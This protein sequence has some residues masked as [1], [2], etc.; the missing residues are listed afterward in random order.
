MAGCAEARR[1]RGSA[2]G[3]ALWAL[4]QGRSVAPFSPVCSG[5]APPQFGLAP[6]RPH[7]APCTPQIEALSTK[8]TQLEDTLRQTTKDYIEGARP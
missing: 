2:R 4:C 5:R 3:A 8:V 6:C 7:L 1:V